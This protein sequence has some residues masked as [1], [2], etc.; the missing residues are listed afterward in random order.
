MGGGRQRLLHLPNCYS[1]TALLLD[2]DEFGAYS[3]L[4]VWPSSEIV[5]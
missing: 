2:T 3:N 5:T 4:H 1:T